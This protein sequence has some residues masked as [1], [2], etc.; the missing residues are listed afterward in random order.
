MC[1]GG[2]ALL[3]RIDAP[4]RAKLALAMPGLK[5]RAKTLVE[6]IDERAVSVRQRRL[7]LDEKARADPEP[8]R[9]AAAHR[10]PSGLRAWTLD[11]PALEAE[12]VNL[13]ESLGIKLGK[14]A[15]PLR[16]ALTGRTHRP[17]SSMSWSC[18]AAKSR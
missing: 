14:L 13:H 11:A 18:W 16:A 9:G 3:A 12:A 5:E 15:Q 7:P 2:A 1:A 4:M 8:R 6:L 10:L 17:A